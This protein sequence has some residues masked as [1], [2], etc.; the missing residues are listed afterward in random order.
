MQIPIAQYADPSQLISLM[1]IEGWE[2]VSVFI[3]DVAIIGQ[4]R[5]FYFKRPKMPEEN[6]A[7]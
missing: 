2:L 7:E 3:M 4:V 5:E 6:K 1:G